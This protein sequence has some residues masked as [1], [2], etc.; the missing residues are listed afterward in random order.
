MY[1]PIQDKGGWRPRWNSEFSN[2]HKDLNVADDIRRL[3]WAGHITNM[4][5]ERIPKRGS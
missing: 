5:D 2:L 1:G 4:E 3:G